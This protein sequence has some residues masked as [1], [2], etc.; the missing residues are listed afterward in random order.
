M[1][2]ITLKA[3]AGAALVTL[4]AME[5]AGA[6]DLGRPR[7]VRPPDDFA[8]PVE[9]P[10]SA[11][12]RWTGFYLGGTVERTWGDVISYNEIADFSFEQAGTVGTIFAGHNWQIGRSVL[13][14]EADIGTGNTTGNGLVQTEINS[15]GSFRGRAGILLAPALLVYGTAGLAWSNMNFSL[16][17][18]DAG[19][20]TLWG[21]QVGTGAELMLTNHVGVRLEYMYTELEKQKAAL[22]GLSNDYLS[23]SHTVRAGVSFK[24]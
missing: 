17:G 15:F 23:E 19:T 4:L 3:G 16:A 8:P 10:Y 21:Y 12:E 7:N 24:F 9:R 13:G 2:S 1:T 14:L 18:F 5:T 6:A 11:V 20:H 22:F